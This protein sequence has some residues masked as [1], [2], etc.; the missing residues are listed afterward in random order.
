M[1]ENL[2]E[3]AVR[4]SLTLPFASVI[5]VLVLSPVSFIVTPDLVS[6]VTAP[7]IA[8]LNGIIVDTKS[9]SVSS[10]SARVTLLLEETKV[11]SLWLGV[12]V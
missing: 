1:I 11:Q 6:P 10:L 12:T 9:T 8:Y 4:G 7:L 2:C 3:D 5:S